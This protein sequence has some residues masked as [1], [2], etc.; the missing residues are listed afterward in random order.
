MASGT[1]PF[2]GKSGMFLDEA[3]V[4]DAGYVF[5]QNED[6][7]TPKFTA[8]GKYYC[9]SANTG[10]TLLNRPDEQNLF[11]MLVYNPHNEE[12]GV[13]GTTNYRYRLRIVI[14]FGGDI[15]TQRVHC[16]GSTTVLYERWWKVNLTGL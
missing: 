13:L 16:E 12:T 10:R 14:T 1:I 11:I 8:T 7:N 2:L 4:L 9:N 6:L 5:Q 3:I 15:Y